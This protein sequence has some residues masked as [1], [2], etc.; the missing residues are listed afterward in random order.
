MKNIYQTI[1]AIMDE[2][3][4]VGKS[5]YNDQQHF[6]YRGVDAVM[7]ALQPLFAKHKLFCVPEVVSSVREDRTSSKGNQLIYSIIRVKYTFYAEDG[8]SIEAIVEGEGMDSGDKATNKALAIAFKY[9]CFQLFCIPT[10]EVSP[11]P[12]RDSHELKNDISDNGKKGKNK[13]ELVQC[14]NC[15]KEIK[16]QSVNGSFRTAEEIKEKCNGLC[17]SCYVK[18]G[19]DKNETLENGKDKE[20]T[21]AEQTIID[22]VEVQSE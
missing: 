9:A 10:E 16:G 19:K 7:N 11:D 12:D 15:G 14:N 20:E 3:E 17:L 6:H 21:K 8:S 1:N 4:P 13:K 18:N 5:S 2:I 22:E